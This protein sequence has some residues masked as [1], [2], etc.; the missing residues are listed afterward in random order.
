M[1]QVLVCVDFSDATDRV[2]A[3]AGR[4]VSG[5]DLTVRLVHV[6]AGEAELAG[7]D[8]EP[9]EAATPD[10]RAAQLRS[11]HGRLQDLGARVAGAGAS[12]GEPILV[13][14]PTAE[15]ITRLA[16]DPEVELVVVGSHGHGGLHHLLMGSVT[17]A[18]VRHAAVPVM[19]VPV[20]AVPPAASGPTPTPAPPPGTT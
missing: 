14:G 15:Q 19:V 11:E 18:L 17:E 16:A 13:M 9:F 12:V 2:V 7:Y 3:A 6:A 1:G 20:H 4:L 5:T 10:K 8:R